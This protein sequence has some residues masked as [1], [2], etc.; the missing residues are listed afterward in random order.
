MNYFI[1][2]IG[3][4][5]LSAII[6]CSSTNSAASMNKLD[7]LSKSNLLKAESEDPEKMYN[8]VIMT[9]SELNEEKTNR[10]KNE[11]VIIIKKTGKIIT[12]ELTTAGLRKLLEYDF[13]KTVEFNKSFF[14][15]K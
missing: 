7:A 14:P 9:D 1:F 10:L 11:N 13:V 4:I 2:F 5:L 6:S 15:N 8:A 3:I 12:V